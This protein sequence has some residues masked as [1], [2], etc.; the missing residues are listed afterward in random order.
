[1]LSMLTSGCG[2][3]QRGAAPTAGRPELISEWAQLCSFAIL[4]L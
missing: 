1:M 3:Q 2:V 4:L